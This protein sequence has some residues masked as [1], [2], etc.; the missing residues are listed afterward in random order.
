MAVVV[1]SDSP[2]VPICQAQPL[3]QIISIHTDQISFSS[4]D[5]AIVEWAIFC[6]RGCPRGGGRKITEKSE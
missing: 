4:F 6:L 1:R 3:Q 5:Q 2:S